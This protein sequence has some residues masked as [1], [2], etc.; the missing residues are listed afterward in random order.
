MSLLSAN[1]A[2][3]RAIEG[4][5][6]EAESIRRR[7][8]VLSRRE[9]LIGPGEVLGRVLLGVQARRLDENE[10]YVALVGADADGLIIE[11]R[12]EEFHQL[13]NRQ[14]FKAFSR[15]RRASGAVHGLGECGNESLSWKLRE[16]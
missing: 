6:T 8:F 15:T 4:K 3:I 9:I 7:L 2:I 16:A 14:S 1:R 5:R 13:V 12:S 10:E 11:G